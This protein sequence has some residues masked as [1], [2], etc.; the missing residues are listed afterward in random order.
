MTISTGVSTGNSYQT[1]Y[2]KVLQGMVDRKPEAWF[3]SLIQNRS[4]LETQYQ[5]LGSVQA[6]ITWIKEMADAELL[7]YNGQILMSE[8]SG[9]G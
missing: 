6:F 9:N 2:L 3:I 1:L 8:V 4:D 5:K 7:G